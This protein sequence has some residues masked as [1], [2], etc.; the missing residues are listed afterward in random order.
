VAKARKNHGRQHHQHQRE[1]LNRCRKAAL[2]IVAKDNDLSALT[3][4]KA[5]QQ[6]KWEQQ[7]ATL[8]KRKVG[9]IGCPRFHVGSQICDH[10][11]AQI[12]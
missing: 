6:R 10:P 9:H 3:R 4:T 11:S 5:P 1:E 2:Y 7:Q 12:S 8:A